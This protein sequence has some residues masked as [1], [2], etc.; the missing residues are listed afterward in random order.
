[1]KN[2]KKIILFFFSSVMLFPTFALEPSSVA[3]TA[4]VEGCKAYSE[5]MWQDSVFMLK[6]AVSYSENNNA[7]TYYMLISA[8]VYAN[9]NQSALVDCN[10]FFENFAD[11]LYDAQV[12]YLKGRVLYNL[13]EYE[14]AIVELSDFCHQ[15]ES[16]NM[17]PV[18]LYWIG[19]SLFACEKYDEAESVFERLILD[20]PE[21]SKVVAAQFKIESI[22]QRAREEKLLYLLKQT[23]EEYL[24]AKEDYE[25]QLR[26]YNSDSLTKK[27]L[28][29]EQKKN[30]DLEERIRLLE[31][32]IE[33]LQKETEAQQL[34]LKRTGEINAENNADEGLASVVA[35]ISDTTVDSSNSIENDT[36]TVPQTEVK[37][38]TIEKSEKNVEDDAALEIVDSESTKSQIEQT[39]KNQTNNK[40][41]KPVSVDSVKMLKEK[42]LQAQKFLDSKTDKT[43]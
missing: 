29:E 18:A 17:Y 23:G 11:S 37:K 1:M 27:K 19:E 25:K 38:E 13:G 2:I 33:Q 36:K 20:F 34:L 10:Y 15:N 32:Q 28:N 21:N 3:L 7:E 31:Q 41:E 4:F 8:E 40:L 5:G 39:E 26:I 35:N 14:N 42:A 43:E 12:K 6:K 30:Q 16:H 9:E 24:A 22:A